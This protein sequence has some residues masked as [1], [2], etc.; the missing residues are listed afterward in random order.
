MTTSHTQV[1]QDYVFRNLDWRLVVHE[2]LMVLQVDALSRSQ[3]HPVEI[4][5]LNEAKSII[6][7]VIVSKDLLVV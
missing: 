5:V 6:D 2:D 4:L 1:Y 3:I 7:I